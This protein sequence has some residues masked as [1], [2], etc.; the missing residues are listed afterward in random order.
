MIMQ[1][2]GTEDICAH[3]MYGDMFN[4]Y[5]YIERERGRERDDRVFNVMVLDAH[6]I[7]LYYRLL[8]YIGCVV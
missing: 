4:I 5:I 2:T 8:S 6:S 3:R 7:T 1:N